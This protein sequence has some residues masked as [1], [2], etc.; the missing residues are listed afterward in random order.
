MVVLQV[1]LGTQQGLAALSSNSSKVQLHQWC[2][3]TQGGWQG[4][5]GVGHMRWSVS[6]QGKAA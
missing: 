5:Q 1:V 6:R 3:L 2:A 4:A